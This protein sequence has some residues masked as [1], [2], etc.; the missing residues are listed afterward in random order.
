MVQTN[1]NIPIVSLPSPDEQP[2]AEKVLVVCGWGDD[3][4][5]T[6]RE[7][8]KLWCVA[9]QVNMKVEC[10]GASSLA[11]PEECALCTTDPNDRRNSPCMGDSGG[12]LTYTDENGRTTLFGVV[13]GTLKTPN[14]KKTI[15]MGQ[16]YFLEY[17]NLMFSNGSK[18]P[19]MMILYWKSN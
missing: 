12:Q 7:T 19:W 5:N 8:D 1:Q 4:F 16:K 13:Q 9:Q 15:A 14:T 11:P 10:I 18:R 17:P 6:T 3:L 2:P